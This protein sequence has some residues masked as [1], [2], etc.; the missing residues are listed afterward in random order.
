MPSIDAMGWTEVVIDS[1]ALRNNLLVVRERVPGK[2]YAV[3]KSN[4]YGHGLVDCAK[5]FLTEG[6]DALACFSVNEASRLRK[7]NVDSEVLL[8]GG[9]LPGEEAFLFDLALVPVVSDWWMLEALERE[10]Y[11]RKKAISVHVKL[12]TGM[13]RLGFMPQDWQTL[14]AR[15]KS[16]RWIKCVGLMSHFPVADEFTQ[17]S[18][19]FTKKQIEKFEEAKRLFEDLGVEVFHIANSAGVF[20]Y[21]ESLMDGARVGIALYGGLEHP[22][23]QQAM[24]VRTRLV[25]V[26]GV[27]AGWSISYGRTYVTQRPK[28]IGVIP[29]GY[30]TGFLRSLSNKAEVWVNG[31]RARVLGRVCMDLTV[32]DL[33]GI[34]AKPGDWVYLLGGEGEAKVTVFECAEW[35]GTITYEVFCVLSMG[36]SSFLFL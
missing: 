4:A 16:S 1:L 29:C 22:E 12:D 10:A 24:S 15:L 9:F 2:L 17:E 6:A 33:D 11:S 13:G 35:M 8:L 28:R 5:L 19:E 26:K 3:V 14:Y 25:N 36:A 7:E 34:D 30:A 32:I 31:C 20:F 23:L 27:P 21:P 18:V